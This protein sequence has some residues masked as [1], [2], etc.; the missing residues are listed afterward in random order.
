VTVVR[1]RPLPLACFLLTV[2][3]AAAEFVVSLQNTQTTHQHVRASDLLIALEVFLPPV[4]FA[5]VGSFI[6]AQ[7]PGNR[8]GWLMI[9]TGLGYALGSFT[10]DYPGF[11]AHTHHPTRP[12]G[13]FAAWVGLWDEALYGIALFY[14]LLLFPD[15]RLSGRRWRAVMWAGTLAAVAVSIL[16]AVQR[17]PI[18]NAPINNPVGLIPIP[19]A[20]L[21]ML[22]V[23]FLLS[24]AAAVVSPVLRFRTA[25][26]TAR[27]QLKWF[28]YGGTLAVTCIIAAFATGWSNG[29][30]LLAVA[31]LALFPIFLGVAILRY[32]LYEIDVLINR[33]LV[34]GSL[35]ISLGLVYIGAVL[36]IQALFRL[37]AGQGSD[38]AVAM[39]TLLVAALFSPW[40]RRLQAFIDRRFYRRKYDT[41]R[42]LAA[43]QSTLRDQIDVEQLSTGLVGVVQET[44]QPS[45]VS[46]WVRRPG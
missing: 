37:A 4:T 19:D 18:D 35:T 42:I 6:L 7:R 10:S 11:D 27:Q 28:T 14:L 43:F 31:A 33:T 23:C 3:V 21:G 25:R 26:G 12:L 40:R 36:G 32:R 13:T 30:A 24:L 39:A 15:G 17:G 22:L 45:A 29:I 5:A 34:Y 9:A 8:I 1:G 16:S 46:L 2:L 41:V 44:M 20:I 38:L